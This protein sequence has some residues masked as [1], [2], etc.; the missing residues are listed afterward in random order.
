MSCLS[1]VVPTS[2]ECAGWHIGNSKIGFLLPFTKRSVV[3]T[4]VNRFVLGLSSRCLAE[5]EFSDYIRD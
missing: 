5:S 2:C 1:R 4:T 3:G